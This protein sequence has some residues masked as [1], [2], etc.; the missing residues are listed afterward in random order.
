MKYGD[1]MRF[2]CLWIIAFGVT[3]VTAGCMGGGKWRDDIS[4]QANQ[5][6][7]GNWIVITE[8]SFP[9]YKQMGTRHLTVD[10]PIPEILDQVMR[11]LEK[12]EYVRPK[13]YLPIELDVMEDDFSPGIDA[14][15][16]ELK[17]AFHGYEVTRAEQESLRILV[18]DDQRSLDVLVIRS[19]TALP[20]SSVFMKLEPG[21]WDGA[22]ESR[23][24]RRMQ[25]MEMSEEKDR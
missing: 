16:N 17:R 4:V 23:L 11:S 8:A 5:L 2:A 13:I 22:S 10:R 3:F 19:N 15:R 7:Y 14:Y 21:Y 12:T 1:V 24:R 9:S 20:Y 18:Y 6:G 25:E